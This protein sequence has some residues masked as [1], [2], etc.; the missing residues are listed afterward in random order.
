MSSMDISGAGSPREI[1]NI[2]RF[3]IRSIFRD[4]VNR[5]VLIHYDA[6][7]VAGRFQITRPD[8][9]P[10]PY[11][12]SIRNDVGLTSPIDGGPIPPGTY[13]IADLSVPSKIHDLGLFQAPAFDISMSTPTPTPAPAPQYPTFKEIEFTNEI[14]LM[15][16][17][18]GVY[19][20]ASR[21]TD[22]CVYLPPFPP[23]GPAGISITVTNWAST[24]GFGPQDA[25]PFNVYFN[26]RDFITLH[27]GQKRSFTSIYTAQRGILRWAPM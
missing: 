6:P 1:V 12:I 23:K 19:F 9:V 17:N 10:L 24:E 3:M 20:F 11:S 4:P 26:S 16:Y 5:I 13:R 27:P 18:G 14:R 22:G 21:T 8:Y 15:N 7:G 2:D 25:K